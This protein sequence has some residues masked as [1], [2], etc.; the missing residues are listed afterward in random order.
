ME[1]ACSMAE[2]F[3][4]DFE[5]L[6]HPGYIL[7]K[8]FHSFIYLA[9]L[10]RTQFRIAIDE[11]LQTNPTGRFPDH[12]AL[13]A[14]IQTWKV[15]NALSFTRE[16]I[17]TQG[18]AL[19]AAKTSPPTKPPKKDTTP[20]S[21]LHPSPCT[22]CLSADKVS[23][24]D[25]L[26]SHYSKNPNRLPGPSSAPAPAL[27]TPRPLSN[28]STRLHALLSQLD[29]AMTP[30]DSNAAMLLIAEAAIGASDYPDSA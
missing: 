8:E 18:S 1:Q 16:A 30:T 26:S 10:D 20:R 14:Q 29:V 7:L 24:Y 5:S 27:L 25:H 21:H 9:G 17:S 11:T 13:M 19:I 6:T 12:I 28:T 2:T 22:W 15:A 4:I 3:N 23:R